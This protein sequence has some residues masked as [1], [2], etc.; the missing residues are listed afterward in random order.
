MHLFCNPVFWEEVKELILLKA[1]LYIIEVSVI[2]V[3]ILHG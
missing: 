1:G 2:T 3:G